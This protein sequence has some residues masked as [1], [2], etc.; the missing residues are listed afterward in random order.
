[1]PQENQSPVKTA[2]SPEFS[3]KIAC[4]KYRDLPKNR[5]EAAVFLQLTRL[6]AA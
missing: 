4:G 3:A 5:D 6:E 2:H 1:M